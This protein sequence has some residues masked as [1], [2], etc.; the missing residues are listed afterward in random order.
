MGILVKQDI[1]QAIDRG[2]LL[3]NAIKANLQSCSYDLRVGTI[4]RKGQVINETS[5]DAHSQIIIQ[6]GEIIGIFTLEEVILPDNMIGTV[7]AANEL[8]SRGLLVLNP[9]HI[10]PGFKG[11]I[12]V[13]A[14]NLRKVPLALSRGMPIFTIIFEQLPKST[15]S[16]YSKNISKDQREREY[17]ERDVE[18]SPESIAELVAL[19][20]D[21]PYPTRQEVREI[22]QQH[23]TTVLTLIL[24][25]VA[26]LTGIISVYLAIG[27]SKQGDI[28]PSSPETPA[29]VLPQQK[30]TPQSSNKP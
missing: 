25:F 4:F 12:S 14:L 7:F 28:K 9:G 22:V 18:L 8:S 15:T 23:W 5:P 17:N 30:T 26:S 21:S 27:L 10:D 29:N 11:T 2:E 3:H 20:K 13:K 16:P 6:P 1:E 19:G 24:T